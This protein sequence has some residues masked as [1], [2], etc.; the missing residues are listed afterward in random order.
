MKIEHKYSIN[1][2]IKILNIFLIF[3][4]NIDS[5]LGQNRY[6]EITYV[7]IP[8]NSWC[9][10]GFGSPQSRFELFSDNTFIF[11]EP[12]YGQYG[13]G[14]YSFNEDTV[15]LK[16]LNSEPP[17]FKNSI[18]IDNKNIGFLTFKDMQY[19]PVLVKNVSIG[20]QDTLITDFDGRLDLSSEKY[21]DKNLSVVL[22]PFYYNSPIFFQILKWRDKGLLIEIG[23]ENYLRNKVMGES[24]EIFVIRKEKQQDGFLLTF[25]DKNKPAIWLESIEIR[26][27]S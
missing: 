26:N 18:T 25:T 17:S 4:C 13:A 11:T 21:L 19:A 12:V 6:G 2:L 24:T 7:R 9:Q 27:L 22:L 10:V 15:I 16:Y 8:S 5:L 23:I 3:L 20:V 1:L 14:I